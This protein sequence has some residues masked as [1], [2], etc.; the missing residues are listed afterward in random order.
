[1]GCCRLLAACG[2]DAVLSM[3]D[4]NTMTGILTHLHLDSAPKHVGFS[5]DSRFLAYAEEKT[6]KVVEAMSGAVHGGFWLCIHM[7]DL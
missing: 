3:W 4:L 5:H 6:I 1:M 7:A 2:N